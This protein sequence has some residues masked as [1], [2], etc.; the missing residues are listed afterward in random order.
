M[1][2]VRGQAALQFL[3][4]SLPFIDGRFCV[5]LGVHSR[6]ARTVYHLHEQHYAFTSVRGA[7]NPGLVWIPVECRTE[8]L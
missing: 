4:Q 6:D 7:E 2:A 8:P 5:T 3:L 1:P